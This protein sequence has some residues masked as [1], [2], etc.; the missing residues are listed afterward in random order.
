MRNAHKKL[1]INFHPDRHFGKDMTKV[2]DLYFDS[3]Q[4]VRA[5]VQNRKGLA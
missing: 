5:G 3:R 4:P 2:N 1:L